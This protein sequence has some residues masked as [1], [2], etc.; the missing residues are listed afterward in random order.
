MF[1]KG[2]E[3]REY[4]EKT[5]EIIDKEVSKIMNEAFSKAREIL[6]EKKIVLDA[7]AKKLIEVETLEQEEYNQIIIANGISPKEKEVEK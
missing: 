4:E 6:K 2:V 5:S 3:D 7:I 1:G